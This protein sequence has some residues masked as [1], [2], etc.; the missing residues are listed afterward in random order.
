MKKTTCL[1]RY[2]ILFLLLTVSSLICAQIPAGYYYQAHGKTGAE[3]KTALH[4]I[5]KEASM[6]K[7]G[8]GEGATWEGFFY[9]DQ[10]PDGSVFDMYSNETR[11]FNGFNGIDGMHIE[12]SL[13]NSWWGGIK[14]NAYKD[15]YHLYPADATMNMSKSNNPLGEVSGTPIRDNGLSKM[16]KNGFGNTY[17]GN[18]FE[19]AD[20][21][22]GDFARSYFY[23]ATAYEDY[24]SLWNSPMMQNNTWPVWQSWALQLL[25]EWNKNDLKST[26][27]EERAE[28]VY[29]I[30]GNRNPFIDYPDLVDYIWGDKTSTPYPFPDETEPFLI[31]PRNNKTLDFGILLQ[32]D[33]KTIDLDIQGKN[34][35]ETLNLYWKTGGE[36]SG[37][38]LSQESVTA[39]EAINGKTIH[40]CYMPQTSG[41]GIDTLV[42]KGGGLADSVIVKVSRGATE[43]FMALPA[44]ETTSTQ[45][46]LRWIRHP[47]ATGYRIDLYSGDQQAGDLIISSYIEGSKGYDKAIEIYNGTGKDIDLSKYSLRKQTNGSGSFGTELSLKNDEHPILADGENFLI[48]SGDCTNE[49]LI[50]R[51]QMIAPAEKEKS[52]MSFNG[53]DAI[54]LYHNGIQIDVIGDVDTGKGATWGV[55]VTYMRKTEVTHPTTVC[56]WSEWVNLGQDVIDRTGTFTMQFAPESQYVFENKEVGEQTEY[57]VSSLMP[58]HRYTYRVTALSAQGE[59]E[60]VNTMGIKTSPLESP[61]VLDATEITENSFVANWDIVPGAEHYLIDLY[62]LIGDEEVEIS[63]TFTNVTDGKPLPEGWTGNASGH[64]ESSTNSKEPNSLAFK[65]EKGE[66]EYIQTCDYPA[67]VTELSFWYKFVSGGIGSTFKIE[68]KSNGIWSEIDIIEFVNSAQTA[69]YSFTKDENITAF[70]FT[71]HKEKGNFALDN[72]S[73]TYGGTK[74][75]YIVQDKIVTGLSCKFEN[76]K[77]DTEYYYQVRSAIGD[78]LSEQSERVAVKTSGN[79]GSIEKNEQNGLIFCSTNS[80][81]RILGLQ[82]NETVSVYTPSGTSIFE[83]RANSAVIEI[84]AS[85]RGIYIIGIKSSSEYKTMKVIR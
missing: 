79:T 36:N 33:N 51:A 43:D 4:N 37:L 22:K 47:Q 71:Y 56:D 54:G 30:Q 66:E 18:C 17:T 3:L 50:G 14:N 57:Q 76:L 75:E 11:Y 28:A 68:K 73:V 65:P 35:T 44:T 38:S 27:E 8:S 45:S 31:S 59:I 41:T 15:L 5:I 77:K 80:G 12:H 6:L 60:A 40:I 82:G 48:V 83:T 13:P 7:Y 49:A 9:T 25:M 10:N 61:E 81:F 70:R 58:N 16:G 62:T 63:E 21:Y 67:P 46:T 29:K 74:P 69:S 78:I 72:V 39:N 42:I 55:N 24:A 2:G 85:S 53:D 32:G 1:L 34:L 52:L 19:P 26:R 20:I 64:Y 84:P 23:I